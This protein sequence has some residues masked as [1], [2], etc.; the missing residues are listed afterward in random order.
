MSDNKNYLNAK[1]LYM[2]IIVSKAQG[3]LTREAV[4]MLNVL[5]DRISRRFYY[6]SPCDRKD[7]YQNG[8]LKIYENWYNF[9]PN[10]TTN[11]FAYFTEVFKRGTAFGWNTITKNND[12][13]IRMDRMYEDGSDLN[14]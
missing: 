6:S 3:R 2:E 9:D 13:T 8:M 11:A 7:C 4:K 12:M 1:D 14:I 10:K 5:G